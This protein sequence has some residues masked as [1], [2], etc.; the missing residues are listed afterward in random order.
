[1]STDAFLEY[2]SQVDSPKRFINAILTTCWKVVTGAENEEGES[3]YID[4]LTGQFGYTEEQK[5]NVMFFFFPE[6][7]VIFTL[8][9]HCFILK[10]LAFHLFLSFVKYVILFFLFCLALLQNYKNKQKN[11]EKLV[12]V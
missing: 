7:F 9:K 4:Q 8:S 3:E 1:M 5:L 10:K 2:V 11:S 6:F 12:F